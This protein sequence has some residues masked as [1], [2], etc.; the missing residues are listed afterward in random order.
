MLTV[1]PLTLGLLQLT[2]LTTALLRA[3]ISPYK[4]LVGRV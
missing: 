4:P 2:H 1:H 3:T